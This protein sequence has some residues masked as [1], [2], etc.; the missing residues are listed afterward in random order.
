MAQVTVNLPTLANW[1]T[2]LVGIVTAIGGALYQQFVAGGLTWPVA[3]ALGIWSIFCYLVPD[4]SSNK[5]GLAQLEAL[6]QAVANMQKPVVAAAPI[7]GAGPVLNQA[8]AAPVQAAISPA[9]D[10]AVQL[11]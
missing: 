6:T 7:P 4:A 5:D 11:G 9:P 10:A 1:K 3:V 2:T 8:A